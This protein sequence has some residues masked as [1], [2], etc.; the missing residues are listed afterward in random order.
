MRTVKVLL[1][2]CLTFSISYSS[3]AQRK[4]QPAEKVQTAGT[5]WSIDKANAWYAKQKWMTGANFIPSSA[6]N[7][8]EMWQADTYDSATID[9][10]LGWASNIG[11]NTMRTFLHSIAWTADPEGFKKRVNTYLAIANKHNIKTIFVIFDDVWNK[12]PKAGKQP[13]PKPGTHNSGWMQ[14]PG[15]KASYD[16]TGFPALEKYVKDIITT[17][18][19][20]ERVIMWDLYNEPGNSG[21]SDSSLNLLKKVFSWARAVNPDQPLTVGLWK[22]D[23]EALNSYQFLNSDITSYHDYEEPKMHQR[24]IDLLKAGGR[25]LVCT[26]YMART[27]DSRFSNTLPLLKKENVGAINWGLVEGKTNTIYEWNKPIADGSQPDEWFHDVFFRDGKPYRE[28]EVNL[29]K[30]LNDKK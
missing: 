25:P 29:I 2:V 21:K 16:S 14:D 10:E 1:F 23:E 20:D 5:V 24:V 22:W 6:I 19:N 11:F 12:E 17:F 8:L 7:Q 4:K 15:Q 13:D 9:R 3:E 28:D 26:E 27:R 30:K 18:K